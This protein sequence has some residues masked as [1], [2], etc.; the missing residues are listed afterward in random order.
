MVEVKPIKRSI[1]AKVFLLFF[2]SIV[3]IFCIIIIILVLAL[4]N[5]AIQETFYRIDNYVRIT[6]P[7]WQKGEIVNKDEMNYIQGDNK[8][9]NL[10][11]IQGIYVNN[12]LVTAFEPGQIQVEEQI[13]PA[14]EINQFLA[15]IKEG[16]N[17]YSTSSAGEIYYSCAIDQDTKNFIIFL[18]DDTYNE[19]FIKRVVF[20]IIIVI[21]AALI[22]LASISSIWVNHFVKRIKNLQDHITSMNKNKYE[23]AYLDDGDDEIRELSESIED[24]RI[25]IK[26]N[27]TTKREMLQNIS[28]DFKTP[29]AV[30]KNYAEAIVDGVIS[31]EDAS[32]IV[33]QAD[34]LKSKVNQLLQYN[35]LEYLNKDRPF[36]QVDMMEVVKEVVNNH[37]VKSNIK[38]VLNLETCFFEGYR[39]NLDT[40]V[41]N[42]VDNALR[43]AKTTIKIETKPNKITIYNDGE[44]IE[45]KFLNTNFK[46]YEKGSKGVFGLGMSIVQKTLDFFDLHLKVYNESY[47]GVSF[48]IYKDEQ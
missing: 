5:I 27:E 30:I 29:I 13:L 3:I 28:H 41:E 31:K 34:L 19:T 46:P 17:A 48:V 35:R 24:L 38:F 40:V 8:S 26:D 16:N 37:K 14:T 11:I 32:V 18:V 23:K 43:Y 4:K 47:G 25:E 9:F 21:T 44:P 1:S 6:S 39:E 2:S 42:I 45:E 33:K 20:N 12:S 7:L 36:E 10:G 15:Q 22:I